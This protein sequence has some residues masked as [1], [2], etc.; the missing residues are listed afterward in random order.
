[1]ARQSLRNDPGFFFMIIHAPR[2][3]IAIIGAGCRFP[4][5]ASSP[6]KLWDLLREPRDVSKRNP[7]SRF[8]PAGFYHPNGEHHGASNVTK[9]YFLEDDPRLFDSVFFNITPREAEAIDPQQR[10]LLETVYEAMESSGLTLQAL[11]GSQTSVYVGLMTSDYTDTQARDPENFSQYMATGTSRALISNRLSYF[12]DWKGPSMTIDTACSSSLTAIHLAVQSLRSGESTV[13]CAAGANLLLTPD[14]FIAATSLHM[15]SPSGKSQMWDEGAD[16]YAR[17]E[18]LSAVFLKTLSQALRD[19]D[20]IEGLIRETGFNSDGGTQGIKLPSPEAQAALIRATY[21]NAGLDP[22]SDRPQYFAAHGTGTQAGDPREAS[23]ISQAFF[24][25]D[26]IHEDG[27]KLLVGSIKTIIG[28]TEGCAGVAGVLKAVLAMRNRTI[29]PNQHLLN[30]NSSVAPSYKHLLVPTTATPWPPVPA[31]HPLRASINSFGFGGTNAHAIVETYE[32]TV[33]DIG[34]WGIKSKLSNQDPVDE[35]DAQSHRDFTSVPLVLSA[36]SESALVAM[37]ERYIELA[38]GDDIS[39]GALA[40]TLCNH[41]STLPQKVF[42]SGPTKGEVLQ[43]MRTTLDKVKGAQGVLMGSRSLFTSEAGSGTKSRVLGVFT[44]QGAQ[45][46][47]MGKAIIQSSPVFGR[48]IQDLEESLGQLPDAPGWSLREELLAP[49]AS[50]R[51][52]EAALSQPL[53]TAIQIGLVDLL[54]HA[55]VSF[56]VVVGHSSGEIGAAYAAGRF[57]ASDAIR[58]AYYRGVHAQL[59][60]GSR[61]QKGAM[62]AVGFGFKEALQFCNSSST[63]GRLA[64]AASNSPGSVTL[65]GDQDAVDEAKQE[66]DGKGLLS[67]PS[68]ASVWRGLHGLLAVVQHPNTRTSVSVYLDF[69]RQPGTRDGE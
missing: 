20:R 52:G 16:G 58:I 39:L 25:P 14:L 4:G 37:V 64:V 27:A 63:K 23:A 5:G 2:E 68:H 45:W 60:Q 53:C 59:A 38:Q 6:S 50:S 40:H 11:R 22:V 61:G 7:D 56:D 34:P 21:R 3:P 33:H 49:A 29:P 67:L 66:L 65:S 41:R 9:S 30:L 47:A 57:S 62:I 13:A 19:G 54:K 44:G 32:P 36:N 12:F 26:K 10:V 24:P 51:L 1:M 35:P 48:I 42:F 18:G 55:G 31:N 15:I 46:P 17:G 69:K 28:Y 8:D 43:A